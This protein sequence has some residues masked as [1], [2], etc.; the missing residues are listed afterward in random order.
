MPTL[1][2][3]LRSTVELDGSDLHITASS[4]PQ[5]RVDGEL[6]ALDLPRLGADDTREI[7]FSALS[8]AQR[9]RFEET[10]ELDCSFGVSGVARFRCNVFRQCGA[11]AAVYRL[12][13]DTIRGLGELGLPPVVETWTGRPRGL[14]ERAPRWPL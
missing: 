11:V 14:V 7:V 12:V 1:Q 6:R 2:E 4:P 5:V 3:L 8:D 10:S 9:R 13:P